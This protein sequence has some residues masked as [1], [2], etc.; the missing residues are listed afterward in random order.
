MNKYRFV[1]YSVKKKLHTHSMSSTSLPSHVDICLEILQHDPNAT[2]YAMIGSKGQE[3][4]FTPI[5]LNRYI[6]HEFVTLLKQTGYNWV[7][8]H[9]EFTKG[10]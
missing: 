2:R 9:I 6:S 5:E 3:L 4:V 10:F 8:K 7:G 1:A